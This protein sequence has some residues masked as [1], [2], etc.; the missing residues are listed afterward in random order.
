VARLFVLHRS[1]VYQA[2]DD[3]A[4]H[5]CVAAPEETTRLNLS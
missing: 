4:T 3:R 2:I 5:T 1:P